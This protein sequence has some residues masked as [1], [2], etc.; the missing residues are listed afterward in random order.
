MC[1][2]CAKHVYHNACICVKVY[3][4]PL[5]GFD[6]CIIILAVHFRLHLSQML[7]WKLKRKITHSPKSSIFLCWLILQD[8]GFLQFWDTYRNFFPGT[9]LGAKY[10]C[11]HHRN[12]LQRLLISWSS[13]SGPDPRYLHSRWSIDLIL[14]M[15]LAHWNNSLWFWYIFV[16]SYLIQ[17]N[18]E[19]PGS[20]WSD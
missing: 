17:F 9:F 18:T 8:S 4:L 7:F 10:F 11:L 5:E 6:A 3:F 12:L 13:F 16:R 19:G 1:K 20:R 15:C 14:Y 2:F